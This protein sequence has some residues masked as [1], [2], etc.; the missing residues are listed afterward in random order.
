MS[1]PGWGAEHVISAQPFRQIPVGDRPH[2]ASTPGLYEHSISM[3]VLEIRLWASPATNFHEYIPTLHR[4]AATKPRYPRYPS[5][6]RFC[7][8]AMAPGILFDDQG[9]NSFRQFNYDHPNHSIKAQTQQ[10]PRSLT[11]DLVWDPATLSNEETYT[12][13]LTAAEKFEIEE[14]LRY[15]KSKSQ[16]IYEWPSLQMLTYTE[17]GLDGSDVSKF[18]FPLHT[19][20]ETL[21]QYAVEVHRGRGF[22]NIRGLNPGDYSLEDNVLLFLGVS[23]Y[24]GEARGRQDEDGNMLSKMQRQ[25]IMHL[26]I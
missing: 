25:K 13:N 14:A 24:I 5:T 4:F 7:F 8:I 1:L 18:T 26:L 16:N 3:C 6:R 20:G 19:F 15:F 9:S 11:S 2:D 12:H 17:L 23:S 10:W 21:L 22:V